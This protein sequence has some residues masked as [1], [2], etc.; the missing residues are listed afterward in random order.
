MM[1]KL[2]HICAV[3]YSHFPGWA[4]RRYSGRLENKST[5]FF[6]VQKQF[7]QAVSLSAKKRIHRCRV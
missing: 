5:G 2:E 4:K 1:I 3:I 6:F 7:I